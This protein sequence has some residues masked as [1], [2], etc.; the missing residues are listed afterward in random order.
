MVNTRNEVMC[1]IKGKDDNTFCTFERR[2]KK[3]FGSNDLICKRLLLRKVSRTLCF[4]VDNCKPSCY[5]IRISVT[6]NFYIIQFNEH[7]VY[8]K[9]LPLHDISIL[10]K[11]SNLELELFSIRIAEDSDFQS[12]FGLL[13]HE[14][15]VKKLEITAEKCAETLP[16]LK[17]GVLKHIDIRDDEKW[18]LKNAK[19]FAKISD[20]EQ[21]KQAEELS[22]RC[23]FDIFPAEIL[24]NFKRIFLFGTDIKLGPLLE[25]REIFSKSEIF[26]YCEIKTDIWWPWEIREH[27]G[28]YNDL[29]DTPEGLIFIYRYGIPEAN[30]KFLDFEFN[31][32]TTTLVI[33]RGICV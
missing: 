21:W 6:L 32:A 14:I 33:R 13:E 11:N 5:S 28:L 29:R 4:I 22:A 31:E 23:D 10:L 16:H 7:R 3:H 2:Y 25:I 26:E 1:L 19:N 27:T 30:R 18:F 8:F 15:S 9:A 12:I 17:P 24:A 20:F